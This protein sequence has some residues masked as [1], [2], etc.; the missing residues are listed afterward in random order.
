MENMYS[1]SFCLF[2][3]MLYTLVNNFSIMLNVDI[4]GNFSWIEPV[5]NNDANE[6][7]LSCCQVVEGHNTAPMVGSGHLTSLS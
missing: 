2:K 4:G 5:P 6:D 1:Y 3:L 7:K